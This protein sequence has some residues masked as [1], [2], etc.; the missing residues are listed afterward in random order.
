M[1]DALRS[2][3]LVLFVLGVEGRPGVLSVIMYSPILSSTVILCSPCIVVIV[4]ISPSTQKKQVVDGYHCLVPKKYDEISVSQVRELEERVTSDPS[5][6]TEPTQ[7]A[8]IIPES[9]TNKIEPGSEKV[10]PPFKFFAFC[11]TIN[12]YLCLGGLQCLD[13]GGNGA[14]WV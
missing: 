10:C 9:T 12:I 11:L 14:P 3:Y 13:V 6:R 7:C 8:Q 2:S 5:A 4:G 1:H